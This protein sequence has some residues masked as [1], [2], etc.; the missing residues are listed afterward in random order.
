MGLL[1]MISSVI[2]DATPGAIAARTGYLQGQEQKTNDEERRALQ[3]AQLEETRARGRYYDSNAT[4]EP[5]QWVVDENGNRVPLP[6]R[7]RNDLGASTGA[8]SPMNASTT[9]IPSFDPTPSARGIDRA[10]QG[11]S[12]AENSTPTGGT[13]ANIRNDVGGQQP[14]IQIGRPS[15]VKA[16]MPK[17]KYMPFVADD[18]T[19]HLRNQN[20]P[21]DVRAFKDENGDPM[22]AHLPPG[23]QARTIIGADGFYHQWD[24]DS[25]SYV[26][27]NVR[28]PDRLLNGS[29]RGGGNGSGSSAQDRLD[30]L[31]ALKTATA[32]TPRPS[33]VPKPKAILLT[34]DA[35]G[36]LTGATPN[37]AAEHPEND[38][39]Y[40]KAVAD[41]VAYDQNTLGPLRENVK[42]VTVGQN[43]K[44]GAFTPPGTA[45][46]GPGASGSS[47]NVDLSNGSGVDTKAMQAE[48]DKAGKDL[49]DILT[50][51]NPAITPELKAQAKKAYDKH[52]AAI[53]KKYNVTTRR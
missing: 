43:T 15:G 41:S 12:I 48:F 34:K 29:K 11:G 45:P 53:A 18:G 6:K 5:V 36:N 10:L 28:V 25:Q 50:S 3:Q 49:N 23:Q 47:G 51:S 46:T 9:A 44:I 17:P 21:T 40:Q 22:I 31:A 27:T 1:D 35:Q 38:P 37:P 39:A 30:A 2:R 42:N 4:G 14:T 19:V 52:L 8:S 16:P 20:D 33:K 13:L 7:I 26:K 24:G 32:M